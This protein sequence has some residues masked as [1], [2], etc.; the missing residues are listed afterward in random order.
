[1]RD[2]EACLTKPAM[3]LHKF[4]D[5]FVLYGSRYHIED[6]HLQVIECGSRSTYL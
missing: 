5:I 1:M 3:V 2:S 6:M 4:T